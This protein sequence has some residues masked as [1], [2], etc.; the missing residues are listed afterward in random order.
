MPA[1]F[2]KLGLRQLEATREFGCGI[3]STTVKMQK[4]FRFVCAAPTVHNEETKMEREAEPRVMWQ[5]AWQSDDAK[6]VRELL[7]E[8]GA[9]KLLKN[10]LGETPYDCALRYEAPAETQRLLT[11]WIKQRYFTECVRI[12]IP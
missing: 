9:D 11:G 3:L 2:Q 8:A 1:P 10:D 12:Q 5:R 7:L 6:T 4:E